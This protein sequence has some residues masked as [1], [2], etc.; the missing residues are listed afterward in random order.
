MEVKTEQKT[1]SNVTS[2]LGL[3]WYLD[4]HVTLNG[5]Q[6]SSLY[7]LFALVISGSSLTLEGVLCEVSKLYSNS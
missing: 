7:V 5:I 6:D 1:R 3:F 2:K 4:S